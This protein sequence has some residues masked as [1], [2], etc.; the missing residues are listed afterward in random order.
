MKLILLQV[1]RTTIG[2]FMWNQKLYTP[3]NLLAWLLLT[4]VLQSSIASLSLFYFFSTNYPET[5]PQY[6]DANVGLLF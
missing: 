2:K 6:S 4:Y 3:F 5:Q 1:P